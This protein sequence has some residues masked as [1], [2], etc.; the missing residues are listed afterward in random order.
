[1]KAFEAGRIKEENELKKKYAL[2]NKK[3]VWR[4]QAKVDYF[5]GRAK[6]LASKP[7]EEQEVLFNKLNA[8]GLKVDTISDVLGLQTEDILKRRLP[9]IAAQKKLA[10]TVRQARQMVV[11]K[12]I[13]INGG[14]VNSPSY[15]VNIAEEDKIAVKKKVR[16]PKPKA[17][18][19]KPEVSA[20]P[21]PEAAPAENTEAPKEEPKAEEPKPVKEEEKKKEATA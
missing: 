20:E 15:L 8:L 3:E 17:E 4:A 1:M 16:K 11:H 9:T 12:K 6:A 13:I 5:R 14:V 2:K 7:H 18:E 10:D 21:V 19:P